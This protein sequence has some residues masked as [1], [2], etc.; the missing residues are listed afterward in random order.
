MT[1]LVRGVKAFGRFWWDFLVGDTPELALATGVIV[2]LAFLIS[3]Q[4][5]VGVIMLPLLAPASSW[6]APSRPAPRT[7]PLAPPPRPPGVVVP[8]A[9]LWCWHPS[10]PPGR[11]TCKR[12][13]R[14]QRRVPAGPPAGTTADR[15]LATFGER[16]SHENQMDHG[17]GAIV[18]TLFALLR[19]P[20]RPPRLRPYTGGTAGANPG[21]A[22]V[23]VEN[24][25]YGPVL[26][27]GGAGAG[28]VPA[29]SSTPASYLYP[30][31]RR[32]TSQ[33]SIRRPSGHHRSTRTNRAAPRRCSPA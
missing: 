10:S 23:S 21:A 29:T 4:R 14:P 24:G 17:R 5:V 30:A 31:G 6:P 20:H 26:V 16:N 9:H 27:V 7:R 18:A 13:Y 19:R 25:P 33:R 8:R 28:Y 15:S 11:E 3:G 12:R 1:L 32:C 2:A 22:V